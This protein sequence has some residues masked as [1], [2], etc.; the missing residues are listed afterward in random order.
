LDGLGIP[1]ARRKVPGPVSVDS[2]LKK[3][4]LLVSET[5][6]CCRWRRPFRSTLSRFLTLVQPI[7]R[8]KPLAEKL[9]KVLSILL[10]SGLL[11]ASFPLNL[12]VQADDGVPVAT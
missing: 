6:N 2:F 5:Q 8:R 3:E 4:G 7:R 1:Q 11:T 12:P 9:Q 10:I